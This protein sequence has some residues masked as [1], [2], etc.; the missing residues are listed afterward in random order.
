MS[1][2]GFDSANKPFPNSFYFISSVV[3]LTDVLMP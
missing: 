2:Y 3:E 1:H